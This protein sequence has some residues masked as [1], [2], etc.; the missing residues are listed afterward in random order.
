M[1]QS[2]SFYHII[3]KILLDLIK[4]EIPRG[5]KLQSALLVNE[6]WLIYYQKLCFSQQ[7]KS[8]NHLRQTHRENQIQSKAKSDMD[9]LP[10]IVEIVKSEFELWNN[11]Q[12]RK[13]TDYTREN[14][15]RQEHHS[16]NKINSELDK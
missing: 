1:N 13:L 14:Q 10:K 4:H 6:Q 15:T 3:Y 12:Q 9:N 8:I 16:Q 2:I 7:Q 11:L 5:N